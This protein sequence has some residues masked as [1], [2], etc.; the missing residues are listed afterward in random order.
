MLELVNYAQETLQVQVRVKAVALNHLDLWG[1]RGM[2]FAKRQLPLVVGA[3]ASAEIAAVG[4]GVAGFKPGDKAV[5]YGAM[6]CGTCPA[7]RE[8][9]DNL[10]ESVGGIMGFHID[11]F[12]RIL[13]EEHG[14]S[15]SGEGRH[16]L[17]R[18]LNAVTHTGQLVD[19]LLNLARIGR[20]DIVRQ[21]ISLD[22]LV[23]QSIVDLPPRTGDRKIDW[24]IDPLPDVEGDPGLLKLVFS[25]L[26]S[27]AAKFT[28]TRHPA[29]IEIGTRDANGT[30]VFF[31]RDNGVG[32]DA[33]YADKLFGVFQRLHRQEDFEGTGVGLATVQRIIHKHGG[34]TWAESEPGCGATFF[35]TLG[36]RP[37]EPASNGAREGSLG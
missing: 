35:F 20:R 16:Y 13:R 3:E 29:V 7:C 1:F 34:E 2:A 9:R 5:M 25:N 31:V 15:L 10:C 12:A 23:R 37:E 21:K 19:D 17:D 32:F 14:A 6:T 24:R 8:G 27:N 33:K 4:T 30:A 18:I 22:D 36:R 26:L 11:G 28:R